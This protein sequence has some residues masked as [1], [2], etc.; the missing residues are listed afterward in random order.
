MVLE[1][2][3]GE[4]LDLRGG[5]RGHLVERLTEPTPEDVVREVQHYAFARLPQASAVA[6]AVGHGA[7]VAYAGSEGEDRKGWGIIEID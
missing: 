3:R 4:V 1:G 2:P 6:V 5:L 7:V